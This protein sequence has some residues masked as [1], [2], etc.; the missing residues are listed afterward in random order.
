VRGLGYR[1]DPPDARDHDALKLIRASAP[2]PS[3]PRSKYTK[4][5]DQGGLGSCTCN[6]AAQAVRCEEIKALVAS[7]RFT[8]EQA[9]EIVE[10]AARL[11]WY[12]LARA[13]SKEQHVDG[14]TFIRFV[15]QV[16][17]TF[18]FPPESAWSYSDDAD[19]RTGKFASMPDSNAF[20]RAFD[21]KLASESGGSP[22]VQY[23]RIASTGYA[24]VDDVKRALADE[25]LVVFGT[26][27]S[28]KFC[29]DMS[30]NGG[31]PIDPPTGDIAGGHAMVWGGYDAHGADTLNS[32][33]EEFGDGGWCKFSWD[34]V[35]SA[36]TTDLWIVKKAPLISG[37]QEAA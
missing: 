16:A 21:Q 35:A 19:P 15:F 8:L 36:R 4:T 1:V 14:G 28:N 30:G 18:G 7:G 13:I 26:D 34:Y 29:G 9:Q 10:F 5:L 23:A 17:N 27:V 12:Y 32:W 24:R 6:A 31:N 37:T 25:H 20:R 11:F 2:P 22:V 3:A 33:S